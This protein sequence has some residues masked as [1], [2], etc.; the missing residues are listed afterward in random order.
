MTLKNKTAVGIAAAT[1][2]LSCVLTMPQ[3]VRA[4][5][6][7]SLS[8]ETY[9]AGENLAEGL[10]FNRPQTLFITNIGNTVYSKI[11]IPE[12]GY[13]V[14]EASSAGGSVSLVFADENYKTMDIAD[15]SVT[16]KDNGEKVYVTSTVYKFAKGTHY[17]G[18]AANRVTKIRLSVFEPEKLTEGLESSQVVDSN[19]RKIT[20]SFTA[21]EGGLY[22]FF[23]SDDRPTESMTILDENEKVL[24]NSKRS[25]YLS[26]YSRYLRVEE[27]RLKAGERV[28]VV[29]NLDNDY[30]E[31][32][33]DSMTVKKII[34][35]NA[36]DLTVDAKLHSFKVG[37]YADMN[38]YK[39][40]PSEDEEIFLSATSPVNY[41]QMVLY[42]SDEN[43]VKKFDIKY[44]SKDSYGRT[45][46]SKNGI[47]ELK[48]GKE[49]YLAVRLAYYKQGAFTVRARKVQDIK[50]ISV[51][52]KPLMKQYIKNL[53]SK[54][55]LTGT[56]IALNYAD[57]TSMKWKYDAAY[58]YKQGYPVEISEKDVLDAKKV[59]IAYRGH[60]ADF[61][62]PVTTAVKAFEGA[63]FI[64]ENALK[65]ATFT[66]KSDKYRFYTFVPVSSELYNV[67]VT[68]KYDDFTLYVF[69]DKG[70]RLDRS[71]ASYKAGKLAAES[72]VYLEKGK[73]YYIG[74]DYTY[75][76]GSTLSFRVSN[77]TPLQPT[78][79]KV[80]REDNTTGKISWKKVAGAEGYRI[81]YYNV[82]N[83]SK[84]SYVMTTYNSE[85]MIGG[86]K[87]GE[88]YSF[89]VKAYKK[90]GNKRYYGSYSKTYTVTW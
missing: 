42:G 1:L 69:D 54:L 33:H 52:H 5:E 58:L 90:E 8:K 22:S 46:Y 12:E 3:S 29:I 66:L 23:N 62:V 27:L 30:R 79:L 25:R 26:D 77:D 34:T 88:T 45:S 87:K 20:Y 61:Y 9:S 60:T 82:K 47:A 31:Q 68:G 83:P 49:Y 43:V 24:Y 39:I 40:N 50:S 11:N 73:K 32:N 38:L 51:I 81:M 16:V 36:S 4:A 55:D 84:K 63:I 89:K 48:K 64:K 21:E 10:A 14:V 2:A 85:N 44:S 86:L 72:G 7:S 57:G 78:G 28:Y 35:D 67:K 76:S 74:V 18:V 56:V 41:P 19:R 37:S 71:D 70:N 13:Y 17:I 53:D 15:S 65:K 80:E 59:T 6:K 75:Y